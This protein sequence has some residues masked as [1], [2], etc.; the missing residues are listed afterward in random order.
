[1]TKRY[2]GR[3]Y[4]IAGNVQGVGYRAFAAQA[5][6]QIGVKGWVRNLSNGRVEAF[7]T[8]TEEQLDILEAR[9]RQGPRWSDVRAFKVEE[10]APG[11]EEDFFIRN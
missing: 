5:G 3:K 1:M 7:A 11:S 2:T 10:A 9:L 6:K 8:G 4:L